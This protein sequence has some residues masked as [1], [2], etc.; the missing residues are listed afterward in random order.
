M[1]GSPLVL[2][3]RGWLIATGVFLALLG[4][5]YAAAHGGGALVSPNGSTPRWRT[6]G[7]SSSS[8]RSDVRRRAGSWLRLPFRRSGRPFRR[9][10]TATTNGQHACS[11][12][13]VRSARPSIGPWRVSSAIQMNS[14]AE[15]RIAVIGRPTPT[16]ARMDSCRAARAGQIAMVTAPTPVQKT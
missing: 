13:P 3:V 16:A 8:W 7:R 9:R 2:T 4:W 15:T 6:P 14:T 10:A 1:V 5:L 12:E 11:A